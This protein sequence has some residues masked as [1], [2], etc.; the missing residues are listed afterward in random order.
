M[1][2]IGKEGRFMYLFQVLP[3]EIRQVA[4]QEKVFSILAANLWASLPKVIRL[5]LLLLF[6]AS[7]LF[8]F[9]G[10]SLSDLSFLINPLNVLY[11][12]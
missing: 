5:S 3:S 4:T 9:N 11:V 1:E 10:H 8:W 6:S 2:F 12:F 7:R